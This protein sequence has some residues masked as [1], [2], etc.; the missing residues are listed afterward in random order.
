MTGLATAPRRRGLVG[1]ADSVEDVAALADALE[2]ERFATWGVSGGGPHALACAALMPDRVAAAATLAAYAPIDAEGLDWTA[3]MG[4]MNLEGFE[5][6]RAGREA[7]EE[8]VRREAEELRAAEHIPT[9]EARL[10]DED[11]HL[12]LFVRRIP[13]VHEWLLA[14]ARGSE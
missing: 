4:E 11:G 14:V 9:V 2:V 7:H 12:T 13:E 5:V 10:S 6:I 8:Y 1:V 3:G